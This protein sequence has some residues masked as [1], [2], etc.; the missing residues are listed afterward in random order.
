MRTR[1]I[2]AVFLAAGCKDRSAATPDAGG[3]A[4]DAGSA[5]S[6]VASADARGHLVRDPEGHLV[7]NR[8]RPKDDPAQI[9]A[10]PAGEPTWDLDKAEPAVDYVERYVRATKRY[11]DGAACV[12]AK[13]AGSRD[14]KALVEV[15]DADKPAPAC[16]SPKPGGA[17][18]DA[19]LVDTDRDRLE[20]AAGGALA[21]WPDGSDPAG[22]PA[23]PIEADAPP[24]TLRDV[25]FAAK[26]TPIRT[27][28]YGRGAYVVLTLAGWRPPV[29]PNAAPA[30]LTELAKTTC[31]ANGGLP[32]GLFAGIDRRTMLRV[33]CGPAPS[34]RWDVL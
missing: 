11:G 5:T 2:L 23:A 25:L 10:A 20:L 34:A 6:S 24:T 26:L 29:T 19:F 21:K 8:P 16:P 31:A 17:V 33:R 12:A 18:R 3:V 28:L 9:P 13:A 15:R 27:Q 1:L 30:T 7:P 14:G 4:A 22:P 32:F